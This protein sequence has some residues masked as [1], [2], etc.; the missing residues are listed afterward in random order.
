MAV[1]IKIIFFG[2]LLIICSYSAFAQTAVFC[3]ENWSCTAW[4]SCNQGISERKCFDLNDCQT[5]SEMPAETALCSDVLSY[6][7]DNIINQDETDIDCG[8]KIC[9]ACSLGKTCFRNDDCFEGFCIN[10][11][12]A[13]EAAAPQPAQ[14]AV[15]TTDYSLMLEI[16]GVLFILAVIF[17]SARLM[18][19]LKKQKI[20]II[21]AK[22]EELREEIKIISEKK[23]M[24]ENK[25]KKTRLNRFVDNFN[26]Y[27]KSIKPEKSFKKPEKQ[28]G[29]LNE[30]SFKTQAA[31]PVKE[32]M[33]SNIKEAYDE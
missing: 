29:L 16:L 33:L 5:L 27:L 30:K 19:K 13:F 6:C 2:L 3:K 15:L 26:G 4:G 14:A 8:G 32:F 28:K 25:V 7:Y 20:V 31:H 9:D 23:A 24:P 11:S 12:C 10:N 1:K 22:K 17:A 18:K 21:T